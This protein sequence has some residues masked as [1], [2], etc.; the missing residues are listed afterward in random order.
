MY[1]ADKAMSDGKH[2]FLKLLGANS[3]DE[4]KR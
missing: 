2:V 3:Y 4:L 1:T